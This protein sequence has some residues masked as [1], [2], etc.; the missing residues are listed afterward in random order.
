MPR[1]ITAYAELN[2]TRIRCAGATRVRSYDEM[3]EF[4]ATPADLT[5]AL[6]RIGDGARVHIFE[7]PDGE[8]VVVQPFP[9]TSATRYVFDVPA[10]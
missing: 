10:V 8:Q 6:A 1:T 5:K 3:G 2:A 4:G 9:G 7:A